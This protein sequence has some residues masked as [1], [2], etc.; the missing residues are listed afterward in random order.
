MSNLIL[1]KMKRVLLVGLV[2]GIGVSGFSQTYLTN[3]TK[4]MQ[5]SPRA[6]QDPTVTGNPL[7]YVRPNLP[8]AASEV[9]KV[10]I[11]SSLNIYTVLV[12]EQACMAYNPDLDLIMMTHR[13]ETNVIGTGNDLIN[14][15]STD[16]GN[17][18]NSTVAITAQGGKLHRYPSGV[19]YNPAGNT[20]V[21]DAF[22]VMAGPYTIGAWEGN[23]FAST[24]FGG[25]NAIESTIGTTGAG[26]LLTRNGMTIDN[27]GSVHMVGLQYVG[28]SGPTSFLGYV[29]K[30]TFDNANNKFNWTSQTLYPDIVKGTDGAY[31]MSYT[32][33]NT[34]WAADGSVGYVYF[35]GSDAR[36]G[37]DR[38]S[39]QPVV[40]KSTDGGETWNLMAYIDLKNNSVMEPYLYPLKR[41]W[42]TGGTVKPMFAET[43]GVVDANGNLHIFT[44]AK[45]AY[46]DH[47]DSIGYTYTYEKGAIFELYNEGQG[48]NWSVNYIDTLEAR[49]VPKEESGYGSGEDALSW[50]HRLQASRSADGKVVFATWT[51]TDIE[52]F[53]TEINLYP[54]ILAYARHLDYGAAEVKNFTRN[55]NIYGE[56]FYNYAAEVVINDGTSWKIPYSIT[57]IR[58]TNDPG[59]PVTFYYVKDLKF[60][61][62]D[63]PVGIESVEGIVNNVNVYP[64]PTNGTTTFTIDVATASNV[65]ITL[66][67]LV[68]QTVRN[69]VHKNVSAGSHQFT[70]NLSDL[71]AGVYF[72]NVIAGEGR[73]TRKLVVR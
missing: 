64:N 4:R 55:S 23:F 46:S 16:G 39:Y 35:I 58:T 72:Y 10:K 67:N 32:Q 1:S 3:A 24:T 19:I 43:D 14:S 17:S 60:E 45:G 41:E 49:D 15:T 31:Y 62:S 44:L 54:D 70:T 30:G 11:S 51:D 28:T 13:G 66:T 25:A 29:Y 73:V 20:N 26:D 50:G 33:I 42:S 8:K 61:L 59:L 38:C 7:Q 52:F 36:A 48:D 53:G 2:I 47:I 65:E 63:F 5:N 40:Y 21:N 37:S 18:F 57:D 12:E 68:G 9:D 34:A 22:S 69:I 56:A 6:L 71:K 27:T